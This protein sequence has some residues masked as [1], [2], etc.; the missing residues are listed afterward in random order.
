MNVSQKYRIENI[1]VSELWTSS[2]EKKYNILALH[3]SETELYAGIGKHLVNV[4]RKAECASHQKSIRA[5]AG[6][7]Q[8]IICGSYDGEGTVIDTTTNK[9]IERIEGVDTEIKGIAIQDASI[10]IATRGRSVWILEDLEVSKILDDHS[11]DVK[12]CSFH[13]G[14]FYS[15]SY[16][17]TIKMYEIF[18]LDH[19]WELMQSIDMNSTVWIAV[20]FEGM[21][22]AALDSGE[23]AILQMRDGM[24]EEEK[25]L[26][27]SAYPIR[28]MC[29][30][31]NNLAVIC[32]RSSVVILD[33]LFNILIETGPISYCGDLLA[34]T[35]F[36]AEN[37]IVCGGE[38]G[39]IHKVYFE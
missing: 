18:S 1:H 8:H 35:F 13:E 9:K 24:W 7:D 6:N 27:L 34:C 15:W 16:D 21:L 11:Q 14:R 17:K 28:T 22:C 39:Y 31:M 10:A 38:D 32:N 12:G 37:C 2:E 30:V 29:L 4:S 5:I 26:R 19:S 3:A 33:K 25:R 36:K 23:L 20:F